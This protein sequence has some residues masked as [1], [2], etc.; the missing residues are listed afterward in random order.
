MRVHSY[1]LMKQNFR[2]H[3][4]SFYAKKIA[5]M[6]VSLNISISREL[7][8]NCQVYTYLKKHNVMKTNSMAL[9]TFEQESPL[10][11]N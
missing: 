8:R 9:S 7:K 11:T 2:I 4:H 1:A 5:Q 3:L 6:Q 10:Q